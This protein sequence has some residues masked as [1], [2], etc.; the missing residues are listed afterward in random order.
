MMTEA[1][2]QSEAPAAI[3]AKAPWDYMD[4]DGV[5]N[6]RRLASIGRPCIN[7]TVAILDEQGNEAANGVAGKFAF[8]AS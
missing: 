3:T 5:I 1:F 7:N 4:R 2:G 8:A 6:E